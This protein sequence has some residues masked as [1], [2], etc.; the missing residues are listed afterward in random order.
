MFLVC[1]MS[2]KNSDYSKKVMQQ[3]IQRFYT[4]RASAKF[5]DKIQ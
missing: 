5:D 1:M 4:I 3:L 2:N